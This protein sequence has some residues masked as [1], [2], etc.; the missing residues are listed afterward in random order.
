MDEHTKCTGERHWQTEHTEYPFSSQMVFASAKCFCT[1]NHE[2]EWQRE[3]D[4]VK[5]RETKYLESDEQYYPLCAVGWTNT[6][7]HAL[8]LSFALSN[9]RALLRARI[10]CARASPF[11]MCSGGGNDG[12]GDGGGTHHTDYTQTTDNTHTEI[13]NVHVHK[14][15]WHKRI[16]PIRSII[17]YT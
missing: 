11:G 15:A 2:R 12:D 6:R 8:R 14:S 17:K 4:I 5:S 10:G 7:T 9:F 13:A 1:I 16:P 3:C